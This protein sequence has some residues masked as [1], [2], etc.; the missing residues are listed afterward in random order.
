MKPKHF[1]G[2]ALF[3]LMIHLLSVNSR[4]IYYS[5][6]DYTGEKINIDTVRITEVDSITNEV[7]VR[8]DIKWDRESF[9][10]T[11]M[12]KKHDVL[13]AIVYAL[14]Y[15]IM[16]IMLIWIISFRSRFKL[17]RISPLLFLGILDGIAVLLFYNTDIK[18]FERYTAI[19]FALYTLSI[20]VIISL[21]KVY[22]YKKNILQI[23]DKERI[24]ILSEAGFT[25]KEIAKIKDTY[26]AKISRELNKE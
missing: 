10:W 21:N 23:T 22:A 5:S 24:K 4:L 15:S 13:T 1:I 20:I 14:A 26:Q 25:Q 11:N 3:F 16:T 6:P 8:E 19:Y 9:L 18:H 7:I 17:V 2:V 12:F